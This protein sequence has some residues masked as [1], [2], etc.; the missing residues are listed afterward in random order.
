MTRKP[1]IGTIASLSCAIALAGCQVQPR[2]VIRELPAESILSRPVQPPPVAVRVPQ[3]VP[4]ESPG[5]W[6]P[7]V[8]PRPW[9]W[10]VIHH[11]ATDAGSAELFD[12]MH[13]AK[14]WDELGYHFVITNGNGAS[15]GLV[16]VGPR[17]IK[18]KWGAHCGGTPNNDYNNYGIGICLVGDF[19]NS[20]PSQ[21]QL[22]SLLR[23]V[24]YLSR[25]YEIDP[26]CVIGHR[27]APNAS[28]ECPGDALHRYV[29]THLRAALQ[30]G[31]QL[32]GN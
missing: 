10:I 9:R 12:R 29:H 26:S 30:S 21:A 8:Y 22:Q 15:D 25:R 2:V 7:A 27:D 18:Q 19:T 16:Q 32:A 13:R 6:A 14:G 24:S 28:T 23:L 1:A 3:E 17:W 5:A 11:S 20:L 31:G 4:E